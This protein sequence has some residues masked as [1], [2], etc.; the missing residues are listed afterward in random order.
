MCVGGR[1]QQGR[2]ETQ[3][4]TRLPER[5]SRWMEILHPLCS[6]HHHPPSHHLLDVSMSFYLAGILILESPVLCQALWWA[7]SVEPDWSLGNS[8]SKEVQVGRQL[9]LRVQ[10][11]VTEA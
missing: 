1:G 9:E 10:P 11:E 7:G 3:N 2:A 6:P 8:K 5:C 4:S